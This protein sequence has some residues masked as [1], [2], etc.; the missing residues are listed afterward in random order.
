MGSLV[1]LWWRPLRVGESLPV[2]PLPLSVHQ[3]IVID[4][5]ETYHRAAK[6]AYLD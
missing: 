5:E 6:R 2:L 4:L 3:A 1:A